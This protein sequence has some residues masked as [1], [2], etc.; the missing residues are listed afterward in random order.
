MQDKAISDADDVLSRMAQG[1]EMRNRGTGWWIGPP[2]RPYG[3]HQSQR[4]ADETVQRLEAAGLIRISVP[5]TS[6][7]AELCAKGTKKVP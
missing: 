5:G 1:E 2:R 6:A 3:P 4:V 7:V